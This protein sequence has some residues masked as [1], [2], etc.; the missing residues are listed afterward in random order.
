MSQQEFEASKT[1]GEEKKT[2][3]IFRDF[4]DN[5]EEMIDKFGE[6]L[7]YKLAFSEVDSKLKSAIRRELGSGT[8]EEDIPEKL[9]DWRPDVRHS[10]KKSPLESSVDQFGSL[11]PDVQEEH[12]KRL[13]EKLAEKQKG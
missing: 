9:K 10:V 6:D 12:L 7:V 8:T 4:G 13:R 3:K 1:V 5:L 2:G 11:P